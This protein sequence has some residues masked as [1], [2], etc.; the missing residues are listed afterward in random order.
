M[1]KLLRFLK[2]YRTPVIFVL[3]LVLLQS[4]SDLYLP[5][6]MAD[7]VDKGVVTGDTPY[8][9]KIGGVMMVIALLGAVCSVGASYLSAKASGGFGKDVRSRVFSHVSQF[10]LNEFDKIGT[11][12]LIT[13]TTNDITQVQQ[14]LMMM[15][16]V[17]V[18]APMMCFGGIIMAMY[19]DMTLS[20]VIIAIVPI[21]A[22]LIFVIVRKGI[23]LFRAMQLKLDK[24]N[25]VLRE[26]L[27]GIRVIRS[28]NRVGH[29]QKRFNAANLDLTDTA[30]RVNRIMASLMPVMMLMMNIAS[31]A[32][33]W[34]GGL[35]ID[36]NH[37]EVGDLIAFIQY[38]FQIM[39]SLMFAS[40]MFV[41]IPRASASAVR[42]NEVLD[43]QPD[44]NDPV[45]P[46]QPSAAGLVEFD[47]VTFHYPGAEMPAV[48]NISFTAGPGEI[49]AII[50]GT[51]SGK[52]TLIN[53]IPR[54]Y[55]LTD[56]QIRIGG[57]DIR[58]LT[59][60][61]LRA[62]IGLVPQKSVLFTG[63]IAENIRYGKEDAT[64]EEVR[65]AAEIAQASDFVSKMQ[66]GFES[67][68]AQ[69]GT[70]VSG[71]Q[72]QRLSIARALVRKP[73]I[74]LFDDSFSALDF[75]TDAKL[76]EALRPATTEAT[77]IIV[78]QRVST[79][80]DADRI[81]VLEDG[82][83]AGIGS[84]RELLQSN[85]IYREIVTSQLSEE[86]IA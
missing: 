46:K 21:L 37:M 67:P 9:W 81:I 68:I 11:A 2:P 29:E 80:M 24:L 27:T 12:S 52:S 51:G 23:P 48:S 10:S 42:I 53:L 39:F 60:E 57:I 32:L 64:E 19:K 28:F 38:A 63:T 4:L 3:I 22:L 66:E 33:I 36:S 15:M 85:E 45:V 55:D 73:S 79:V 25:L 34:F 14:V 17:M 74:Y 35:R 31:V 75:K 77:V 86:E 47:N 69:G 50:G 70:N 54:F 13:R 20:L 62:G 41:M 1:M 26:N 49:T 8:I 61:Q 83:V 78:A 40:M 76:R 56:G 58:D 44:I 16:R 59:Q 7:I 84:H 43:M 6:L 82:K 71:G 65:H 30:I 18:M 72:K 5:T